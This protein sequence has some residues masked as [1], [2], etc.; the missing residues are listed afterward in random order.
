MSNE[1]LTTLILDRLK[2][3]PMLVNEGSVPIDQANEEGFKDKLAEA[4]I[5]D[6]YPALMASSQFADREDSDEFHIRCEVVVFHPREFARFVHVLSE[7]MIERG[8]LQAM[9]KRMGLIT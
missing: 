1:E 8:K 6:L 3:S 5:M 7:A 2:I 9:P 4:M